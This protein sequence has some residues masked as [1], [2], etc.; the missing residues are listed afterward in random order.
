MRINLG[1]SER[2]IRS[3]FG[4]ILLGFGL[5]APLTPAGRVIVDALAAVLIL[6]AT[7]GW[8]PL[9]ALLH[10]ST[11]DHHHPPHHRR[12]AAPR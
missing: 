1:P 2:D 11:R 7:L 8:C 5:F 4:S 6:T 12:R 3:L 10:I 9:Y